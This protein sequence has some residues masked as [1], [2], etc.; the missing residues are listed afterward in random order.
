MAFQITS[1]SLQCLLRFLKYF[2]KLVSV[3]VNVPVMLN[4]SREIPLSTKTAEKLALLSMLS[5]KSVT[6][7]MSI[8]IVLLMGKPKV[9]VI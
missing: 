6:Q 9:V 3:I 8:K 4:I 5:V 7:F 1:Q 2:F